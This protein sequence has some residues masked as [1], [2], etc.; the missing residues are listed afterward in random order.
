MHVFYYLSKLF[1]YRGFAHATNAP[2]SGKVFAQM[3]DAVSKKKYNDVA[4][5][6]T[7]YDDDN[8]TAKD[9]ARLCAQFMEVGA[10]DE[11]GTDNPMVTPE[12]VR[13]VLQLQRSGN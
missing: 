7:W 1:L 2:R 10:R 3:L 9:V 13:A 4:S 5:S 6:R 8:V 11:W 12:E